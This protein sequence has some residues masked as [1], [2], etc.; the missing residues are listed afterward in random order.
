MAKKE[1]L[2]ANQKM[3]CY[4]YVLDHNGKRAYMAAYPNSSEKA[5]EAGASRLLRVAKVSAFIAQLESKKLKKLD[6]SLDDVLNEL[7]AIGFSKVTDYASIDC[8]VATFEDTENLTDR[9]KSAIAQ[10]EVSDRG[11]TKIKIH[12]KTKALSELRR[13]FEL[14]Q[15]QNEDENKD[16]GFLDALEDKAGGLDWET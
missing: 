3:F 16:D 2:T 6:F 7:A 1:Q 11:M 9:Q 12:D 13:H 15:G 5:A 10:I 14:A 8:G 4:E